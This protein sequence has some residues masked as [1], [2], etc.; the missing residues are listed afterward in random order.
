MNE[1]E[2]EH[3]EEV[4]SL[5]HFLLPSL[6]LSVCLLYVCHCNADYHHLF[7]CCGL[8]WLVYVL[9]L[10]AFLLWC[11]WI[12]NLQKV[13]GIFHHSLLRNEINYF[14]FPQYHHCIKYTLLPFVHMTRVILLKFMAEKRLFI[15]IIKSLSKFSQPPPSRLLT[16]FLSFGCFHISTEWV[17]SHPNTHEFNLHIILFT[18]VLY[19]FMKIRPPII[20]ITNG[21]RWKNVCKK[22]KQK[23]VKGM[24]HGCFLE[25]LFNLISQVSCHFIYALA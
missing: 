17:Y 3:E 25:L 16:D 13:Y 14:N 6:L 12:I 9:I 7:I 11:K 4:A 1:D 15:K 23:M 19:L 18:F 22:G 10:L 24:Q 2:E 21:R 20:I 8:I 5:Y